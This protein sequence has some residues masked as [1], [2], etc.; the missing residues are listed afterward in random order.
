MSKSQMSAPEYYLV[1]VHEF[2]HL[3]RA[4]SLLE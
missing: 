2:E 4:N 3:L 1:G